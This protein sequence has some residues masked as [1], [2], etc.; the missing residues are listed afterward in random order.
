M[1]LIYFFPLSLLCSSLIWFLP[2]FLSL[3][4]YLSIHAL[5]I[6]IS[7]LQIKPLFLL[8]IV[9]FYVY[10]AFIPSL[11]LRRWTWNPEGIHN[12]IILP[13]QH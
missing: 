11:S 8:F 9:L 3:F 5:I 13:E 7:N 2:H 12:S 4:P 10:F 1:C 6:P